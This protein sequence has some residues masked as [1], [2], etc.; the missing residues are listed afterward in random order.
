MYTLERSSFSLWGV[1]GGGQGMEFFNSYIPNDVP[2][3]PMTFPKGV[4]NIT[5]FYPVSFAQS[6]PLRT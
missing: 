2:H 1:G 4:P 3:V 5:S 6:S